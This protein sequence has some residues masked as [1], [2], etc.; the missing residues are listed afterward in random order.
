MEPRK[1]SDLVGHG[2]VLKQVSEDIA[3][4]QK[5]HE[6]L[7]SIGEGSRS[8]N[9]VLYGPPGTGKTTAIRVAANKLQLPIYIVNPNAISPDAVDKALS[10]SDNKLKILL[11]EDFD[12]FLETPSVKTSVMPQI[13]N[14]LDGLDDNSNIIRFFSANNAQIIQDQPALLSRMTSSFYFGLPDVKML[15]SKLNSFMSYYGK[16]WRTKFD[17]E[18][19]ESNSFC[20]A[21]VEHGVSFRVFSSFISQHLFAPFDSSD[22]STYNPLTQFN[23]YSDQ[24]WS[25]FIIELVNEGKEKAMNDHRLT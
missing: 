24:L 10:P 21:C 17:P 11:L 5:Y 2:G 9:Y 19:K 8:L 16:D 3:S 18:S 13:L 20:Q 14:S 22:E 6:F 4:R 12:R 25:K 23:K 1:E 7:Q 15:Q